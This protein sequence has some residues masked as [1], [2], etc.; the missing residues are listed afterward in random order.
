MRS[1][2]WYATTSP[3][4]MMAPVELTGRPAAPGIALGKLVRLPASGDASATRHGDAAA[5]AAALTGAIDA[6][7]RDL[8]LLQERNANDEA[9]AI[10]GFQI[11]MLEDDALRS[12]ALRA[13]AQGAAAG[14]A[15]AAAVG[16]ELAGYETAEDAYFRARA[17]DLRDLRDRVLRHLAGAG[18]AA[19]PPGAILVADD[20]T[21]TRFLEAD[22]RGGGIALSAGAET[23]HV[24]MLARSRGVPMVVG[25][26]KLMI[27]GHATA[28]LDGAA[29]KLVLSPT[30]EQCAR[31][32][33]EAARAAAE[34]AAIQVG[35]TQPAVTASGQRIAVLLNIAEPGELDTLDP[36]ICDG[37][38]VVRTEFL[39]HAAAGLPDE[40]TQYRVY[41]R[42]VEWAA[43]RPVTVRTLDAGGDKPIAGLTPAGESNPFLGLR[44]VRL[45]LARPDVF[46]VQLRALARAAAHGAVKVLV[47]MVTVPEELEAVRRLLRE[48]VA[49]L[50]AAGIACAEPPVGMMVEVPAAALAI[51]RFDAAFYS[52]GSNDL[53]QYVTASARDI[54]AVAGLAD[55]RNPAVWRLIAEVV[56]HGWTSGRAVSVCGDI[57][58]EPEFVGA[59]LAAGVTTL[60]LAPI[61]VGAVKAAVRRGA[62][63]PWSASQSKPTKG[64][65]FG[66]QSVS[67]GLRPLAGRGQS[68]RLP[69]GG[70][71]Q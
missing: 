17:T 45:S 21:P 57:A 65:A 44:G 54:G 15:W 22:W 33:R 68:P 13:I 56:A 23:S 48:A 28:A 70:E 37:I 61:Q 63:P 66:I 24:A 67:K 3:S 71:E 9:G 38:G 19:M 42:I 30:P 4:A 2:R 1:R 6:A 18:E 39:F 50:S 8:A 49:D 25:L 34:Y 69:S 16:A 40:A 26:G 36:A 46:A 52:I 29:G 62:L 27:E 14:P 60:S 51:D 64:E 10:V 47:P 31:F 7:V 41:R 20:L 12:P 59:L 58:G 55:A 53:V 35:L 43:G 5:E 32:I 11:A